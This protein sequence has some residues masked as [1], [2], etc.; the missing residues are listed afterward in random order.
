M[1]C[2]CCQWR[3]EQDCLWA[4]RTAGWNQPSMQSAQDGGD[5]ARRPHILVPCLDLNVINSILVH[6]L[7]LTSYS[8][9]KTSLSVEVFWQLILDS[10][11]L[12]RP[13][14]VTQMLS[15]I[16]QLKKVAVTWL[17][18]PEFF[19]E[20]GSKSRA[21]IQRRTWCCLW[22]GNFASGRHHWS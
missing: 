12:V 19:S 15:S 11:L 10:Y 3:K 20:R 7:L 22:K 9:G 4:Q 21:V 8:Y 13:L 17:F 18:C 2:V 1:F 5:S 6:D 16:F 14:G